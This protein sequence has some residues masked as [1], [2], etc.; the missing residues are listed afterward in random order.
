MDGVDD[1]EPRMTGP[2]SADPV[3]DFRSATRSTHTQRTRRSI[4]KDLVP[5][6]GLGTDRFAISSSRASDL[7][8]RGQS[9][10]SPDR[11]STGLGTAMMAHTAGTIADSSHF[12]VLADQ[13]QIDQADE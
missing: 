13:N 7:S 11:P 3:E 2:G 8:R 4:P 6:I 9:Y 12:L 1:D 5:R 10:D